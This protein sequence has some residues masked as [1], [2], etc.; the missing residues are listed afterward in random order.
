MQE[1]CTGTVAARLL[2]APPSLAERGCTR[3][4]QKN[5]ATGVVWIDFFPSSLP[6]VKITVTCNQKKTHKQSVLVIF[7]RSVFLC[8]PSLSASLSSFLGLFLG[9]RRL[10]LCFRYLGG[11][12]W[13][14]G[15][16]CDGCGLSLL[17]EE[18]GQL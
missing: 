10:L 4:C 1:Q 17:V 6:A 9:L 3:R 14:S 2:H 5:P 7:F 13:R 18:G 12:W 8:F 11:S 15:S 16:V